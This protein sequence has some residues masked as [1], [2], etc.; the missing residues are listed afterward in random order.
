MTPATIDQTNRTDSPCGMA[1]G[2]FRAPELQVLQHFF[3]RGYDVVECVLFSTGEGIG[4]L[5]PPGGDSKTT[6]ATTR[7]G[8][9]LRA[10]RYPSPHE[11]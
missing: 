8:K 4:H 2:A 9:R 7:P 3:H 11:A 1:L 10:L 5:V 6:T